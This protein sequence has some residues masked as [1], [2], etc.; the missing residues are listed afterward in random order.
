MANT[1]WHINSDKVT[2]L[3]HSDLHNRTW[4]WRSGSPRRWLARTTACLV[5]VLGWSVAAPRLAAQQPGSGAHVRG[6]VRTAA[7]APVGG[8]AVQLAGTSYRGTTS[9]SGTFDLV[10]AAPGTY[11]LV[12]R[13]P[14]RAGAR[15]RVTVVAGE[16]TK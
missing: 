13:G 1:T 10:A 6:V 9:D 11:T 8:V 12:A 15:V 14:A 3:C 2:P 4:I 7:G 16:D 5:L